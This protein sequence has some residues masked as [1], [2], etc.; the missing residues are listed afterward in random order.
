MNWA[1]GILALLLALAALKAL[2]PVLLVTL[3]LALAYSLITQPRETLAFVAL[4]ALGSVVSARPG[5]AIG[6][7][8]LVWMATLAISR[9]PDTVGQSLLP[10][11]CEHHSN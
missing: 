3:L 8:V 4:S 7:F 9:K 6:A 5:I 1:I 10:D 2:L 11:A